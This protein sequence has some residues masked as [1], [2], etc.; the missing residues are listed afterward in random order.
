MVEVGRG[1]LGRERRPPAA[2]GVG[3]EEPADDGLERRNRRRAGEGAARRG[4]SADRTRGRGARG[5]RRRTAAGADPRVGAI[6]GGPGRPD[7]DGAVE[8]AGLPRNGPLGRSGGSRSGRPLA[9]GQAVD[10]DGG[11]LHR[12][13]LGSERPGDA[14]AARVRGGRAADEDDGPAPCAPGV[15]TRPSPRL[16]VRRPYSSSR[17]STWA[18][19]LYPVRGLEAAAPN[20]QRAPP[21]GR[22]GSGRWPRRSRPGRWGRRRRRSRSPR[23]IVAIPGRS[24]RDDRDAGRHRLEQLVRGRQAVVERRGLDRHR[25]R[26]RPRRPSRGARPDA[27]PAGRGADRRRPAR[28]PALAAPARGRRSPGARASPRAR[29]VERDDQLLDPA[30]AG[31]G[32]RGRGRR[33][34][35]AAGRGRHG[36]AAVARRRRVAPVRAVHDDQRQ[37]DA[38]AARP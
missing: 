33:A 15:V 7:R 38:E 6:G 19:Q 17:T 4:G 3:P 10:R 25:R 27:P 16:P 20:A 26:R 32:R 29:C 13:A 1:Q 35:P 2:D 30:V 5:R 11:D 12:V 9:L 28:R 36:S 22:R 24:R 14:Q 8:P 21:R 23:T 31:R 37:L 18:S 34:A